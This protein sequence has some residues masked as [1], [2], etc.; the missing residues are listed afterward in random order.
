MDRKVITVITGSLVTLFSGAIAFAALNSI[1]RGNFPW[2]LTGLAA[3][4]CSL[5]GGYVVARMN[6]TNSTRLG[7]LSGLITG[8]LALLAASI[9]GSVASPTS[10]AGVAL[11]AVWTVGGGLG[12]YLTW[13]WSSRKTS[14]A[15]VSAGFPETRFRI[16]TATERDWSWIV[17]GQVEIAWARL[18]PDRQR[19]VSRQTVEECVAQQVAKLRQEEGFPNEAF[20]AKTDEGTP[21]GFVWVAKTHNDFT[22]QLEASLLNQYVA[23][24]YRGQGLGRRL[25]ETAEEWARQQGLL[26]ISLSVGAHNTL[27]QRLYETL[28]YQ[29]DMLRMTKKLDT[30][31]PELLLTDY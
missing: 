15:S 28:G 23:K 26:R 10:L 19:E 11:V 6:Q 30:R 8:L 18:G 3:L 4:S 29:V 12:A 22:G 17:Q 14:K 27:A 21:A 5:I 2:L 25:M 16:E 31:E 24:P 1:Y 20:M 9:A 7:I 13:I